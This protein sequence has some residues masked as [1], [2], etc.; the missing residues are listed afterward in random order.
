MV[1]SRGPKKATSKDVQQDKRLRRLERSTPLIKTVINSQSTQAFDGSNN[2]HIFRL[3][4]S[5]L[6]DQK[7]ELAGYNFRCLSAQSTTYALN[8]SSVVRA[9]FFIYKCTVDN[10]GTPS[11]IQPL[12]TDLLNDNA[13]YCNS[14]Y[15]PDNKSRIRVL[16][17][18]RV[19]HKTTS[20]N[21]LIQQTKKYKK[22]ILFM[23]LTDKAFVY[24]P[25]LVIMSTNPGNG[26]PYDNNINHDMDLMTLQ[27]P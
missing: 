14:N 24:R 13:D 7:V 26:I 27:L 9:I 3:L 25:F 11:V 1:K 17:D 19:T 5:G 20:Y 15:N 10:S 22:S 4:P 23:P 6:D 2:F 12:I 8:G 18:K 16:F 21:E